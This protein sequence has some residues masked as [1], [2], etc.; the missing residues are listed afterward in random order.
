[1]SH[2]DRRLIRLNAVYVVQVDAALRLC[3][4]LAHRTKHRGAPAMSH[5]FQRCSADSAQ[6]SVATVN[7]VIE[8]KISRFA[9][10]VDEI[11][12]R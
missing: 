5:E 10:G 3:L 9:G 12:Q 11:A 4:V 1:M 6:L 8:L 2:V 7:E